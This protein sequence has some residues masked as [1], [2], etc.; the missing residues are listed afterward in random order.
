[1]EKSEETPKEDNRPKIATQIKKLREEID[2]GKSREKQLKF[3]LFALKKE[4]AGDSNIDYAHVDFESE[5]EEFE[6]RLNK[7]K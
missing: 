6:H 2:E 3:L 1:M 5:D 7:L 4:Q